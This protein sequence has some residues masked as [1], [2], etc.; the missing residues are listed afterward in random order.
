MATSLPLLKTMYQLTEQKPLLSQS[1][2][3]L[4]ADAY[5]FRELPVVLPPPP[6]HH[7]TPPAGTCAPSRMVCVSTQLPKYI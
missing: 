1:Q 7:G 5:I 2:I 4:P 6:P 3:Y